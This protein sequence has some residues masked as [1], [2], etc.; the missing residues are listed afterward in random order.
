MGRTGPF[1]RPATP[2]GLCGV[3]T[4]LRYT[5]SATYCY[6]FVVTFEDRN[7]IIESSDIFN[8]LSCAQLSM[9]AFQKYTFLTMSK[10]KCVQHIHTLSSGPLSSSPQITR[11]CT[12]VFHTQVQ[13]DTKTGLQVDSVRKYQRARLMT[14]L[15]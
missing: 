8:F 6:K 3:P 4:F 14:K 11:T 13:T 2:H 10:D 7:R 12:V 5:H 9:Q 15:D 1:S